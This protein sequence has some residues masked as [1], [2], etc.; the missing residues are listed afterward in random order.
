M[1]TTHN[2]MQ[3]RK[4]RPY[5]GLR[6]RRLL[7]VLAASAAGLQALPQSLWAQAKP[8]LRV[9]AASDL[10]FA[11]AQLIE[12]YQSQGGGKVEAIFG[13]S[14][15]LARQ[16]QQG[17]PADLFF[18]ADEALVARLHAAGLTQNEGLVYGVGRLALLAR[19]GA[20]YTLDTRLRGLAALLEDPPRGF[21]LALANPEHAPY[22]RAAREALQ[23]AG[24]WE[25]AQPHLVLGDSVVQAA[26]FVTSGAASLALSAHALAL[27]PEISG[28]T[29]FALVDAGLHAPLR[30]RMVL[31]R[32]AS[33]EAQRFADYLQSA[34]ARAVWQRWGFAGGDAR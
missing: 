8:S 27:A 30:Q 1:Q 18:S 15:N 31:L 13:S 22:G 33:S 14:G 29:E 4:F 11:L 12:Q 32:Q 6:R 10:K 16:I 3:T 28:N 21:K 7:G 26:Q 24:L 17:L 19:R 20:G 9:L 5:P 2:F 25:R 23:A 34:A